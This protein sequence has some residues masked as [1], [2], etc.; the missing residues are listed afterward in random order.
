LNGVTYL[1]MEYL[2]GETLDAF[3]ERL[4]KL[5]ARRMA[6]IMIPVVGAVAA[7]HQVD[8]IHRDIKPDNI[9][10]TRTPH[11][12][13]PKVLDF[14]ISRVAHAKPSRASAEIA[15]L[16]TPSY[17]SPE[18]ARDFRSV[19]GRGDQYSLAVV[20]YQC[21]TGTIP[22]D[23]DDLM[24]LL[25]AITKGEIVAPT[26]RD[27]SIPAELE[28]VILRAIARE[29]KDRFPSCVDLGAA[30]LPF[31][32]RRTRMMWESS[33]GIARSDDSVPPPAN[34]EER[35]PSDHPEA[36]R[37]G[38]ISLP[39]P[40]KMPSED[41][42]SRTSDGPTRP[43]ASPARPGRERGDEASFAKLAVIG[44]AVA[45]AVASGVVLVVT[46]SGSTARPHAPA[47]APAPASAPSFVVAPA[48]EEEAEPP[49]TFQVSLRVEPAAAT[50]ALDGE[51]VGVGTF[52]RELPMDGRAHS[53]TVS[54]EGFVSET[55]HF[56]NALPPQTISLEPVPEVVRTVV[57][58][59]APDA[60]EAGEEA[61]PGEE[62]TAPTPTP[63]TAPEEAPT[64]APAP[65][66]AAPAPAE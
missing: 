3:L 35:R 45:L 6:D 39:P 5:D 54:H 11:G 23:A 27:A 56:A 53:I 55:M 1:V 30:L 34:E 25:A 50:I 10:L 29:P 14:G 43:S 33:F 41:R 31:A 17:M 47:A 61:P 21:L 2:E 59:A 18:Q 7:A 16:G 19:D 44:G 62:P 60:E 12:V 64:E 4:G 63:E 13:H 28:A 8:V 51:Q 15:L 26:K 48:E 46:S 57:R 49:A 42:A 66:P 36:G 58:R 9:L 40:P 38:D 24:D 20:M 37:G 32:S 65:E 52:T 22:Y